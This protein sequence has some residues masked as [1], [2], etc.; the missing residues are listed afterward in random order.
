[1][2]QHETPSAK[3]DS[4]I[5]IGPKDHNTPSGQQHLKSLV[6]GCSPGLRPASLKRQSR[7]LVNRRANYR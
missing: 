7:R 5:D 4:K 1:M 2:C 6:L 3:P